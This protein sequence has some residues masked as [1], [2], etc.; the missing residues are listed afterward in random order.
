M[1]ISIITTV[2]NHPRV[3]EALDSV[4]AQRLD[5]GDE[6]ELVV[7]DGGSTDGTLSRL[8][9][10]RSRVA[11]FLS[12]KD[13]GIYDGMNKGIERAS[14]DIIGILN[15][16]DLYEDDHALA[17]VLEIFHSSDAQVVYGDLV[18]VRED[19]P[20][21]VVR[22]WKSSPYEDGLFERGWMPPHPSFFVRRQVYEQHGCFDLAFQLA[23][24][25]DLMIRFLVKARMRFQYVPKVL[26]RMRLGGASNKSVRNIIKGNLE[27]YRACKKNGLKVSLLFFV[28]KIISRIPQFFMRPTAAPRNDHGI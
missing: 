21:K 18:Y 12:E 24:D 6:L 20:S 27:G 4:L 17:T 15:S 23:S 10:Y 25:L 26:V 8:E 9:G 11:V 5:P 16:D 1:K 19:D 22:Y 7:I 28:H 13:S 14:G 2:Y 3:I